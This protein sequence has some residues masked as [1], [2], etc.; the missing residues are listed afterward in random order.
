MV[1]LAQGPWPFYTSEYVLELKINSLALYQKNQGSQS[2]GIG[3]YTSHRESI[4][5]NYHQ[6]NINH[7][8]VFENSY[9]CPSSAL[10][11]SVHHLEETRCQSL[12]GPL[13]AE[14]PLSFTAW[15]Q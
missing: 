12:M 6:D 11:L 9:D 1:L 15:I 7:L 8:S 10:V 3:H 4:N 2:F 5:S 13:V 14:A